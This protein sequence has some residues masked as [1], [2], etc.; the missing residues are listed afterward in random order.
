[1][2]A[3]IWLL[4]ATGVV[5]FRDSIELDSTRIRTW[6]SRVPAGSYLFRVEASGETA[7]RAARSS[8]VRKPCRQRRGRRCRYGPS[9]AFSSRSSCCKSRRRHRVART[10]R[11]TGRPHRHEILA[12]RSSCVGAA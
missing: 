1:V 5:A 7:T 2:R 11:N 3:D 4:A 9:R 8:G 10:R 6:K 12:D